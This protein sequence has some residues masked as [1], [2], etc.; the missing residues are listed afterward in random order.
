MYKSLFFWKTNKSLDGVYNSEWK[1]LAKYVFKFGK[2]KFGFF[3]RVLKYLKFNL[4]FF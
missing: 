4:F 2:I 1:N 3:F